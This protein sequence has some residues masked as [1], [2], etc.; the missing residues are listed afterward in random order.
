LKPQ[1][2]RTTQLGF[3]L[4]LTLILGFYLSDTTKVANAV[5]KKPR[6]AAVCLP[7]HGGSFDKLA[8][9][10]ASFKTDSGM[11]NPHQFIPH[12][13]KKAENVPDCLD[14]HTAHPNPPKEK[15]DLSKVNIENCYLSCHHQQNFEKCDDCHK[16]RKK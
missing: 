9:K 1:Q 8:A 14:C 7:C 10:G 2:K 15:I 5:D 12:N 4:V 3:F 6:G 13:E 11:V 16:D